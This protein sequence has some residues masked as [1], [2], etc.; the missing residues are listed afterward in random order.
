MN[1]R[2]VGR[3]PLYILV[4]VTTGREEF[5][6]YPWMV[7][8]LATDKN[9]LDHDSWADAFQITSASEKRFTDKLGTLEESSMSEIVG[10][11]LFCVRG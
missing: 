6:F 3:L 7:R 5:E 9:G 8:I 11:I 1:V 10:A 4:P 2:D